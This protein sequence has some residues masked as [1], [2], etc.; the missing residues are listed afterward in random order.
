MHYQKEVEDTFDLPASQ[1]DAELRQIEEEIKGCE[2]LLLESI[3]SGAFGSVFRGQSKKDGTACAI[4]IIDLEDSKGGDIESITKEIKALVASK[5]CPQLTKYYGSHVFGTKLW[6]SMEFLDG[7]SVLDQIKVKPLEERYIA[8]VVREILKGLKYLAMEG[9]IHRDIKAANILLSSD[10]QVKLGDFGAATQLTETMTHC[11]TFIGSPYWMAPEIL[12]SSSYDGK[13][14]IWSLGITCL[15]MTTGKPPLSELSPLKVIQRIPNSPPPQ[16]DRTK[17][18]KDFCDF[19]SLCLT[20]DPTK[21]P[22]I[23]ELLKHPFVKTAPKSLTLKLD[24]G[25]GK[26]LADG[27]AATVKAEPRNDD[28]TLKARPDDYVATIKAE[29]KSS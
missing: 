13:A 7:G 11:R 16:P 27:I 20:R 15:E 25:V 19:V 18:S 1:R 29:S 6:I 24:K 2:Y 5:A 26:G 9:K 4:K 17:F 21:R 3:G 22:G 28:R 23:R 10:G 8:V 12:E 14:D